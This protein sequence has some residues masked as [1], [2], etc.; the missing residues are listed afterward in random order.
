[1]NLYR[2]ALAACFAASLGA[3]WA[4]PALADDKLTPA[5]AG[6]PGQPLEHFAGMPWIKPLGYCGGLHVT[7]S[8]FIQ[9]KDPA[10]AKATR[11]KAAPFLAAAATRLE[12]DRGVSNDEAFKLA[13]KE[14][15]KGR[16]IVMALMENQIDE[17]YAK[18]EV[19]C[20]AILKLAEAVKD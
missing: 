5:N 20:A 12:R 17:A 10:Q 8:E 6:G 16:I 3:S 4:T 15:A 19:K 7:R 14:I 9:D 18:A 2:A 1:M 11:M 13:L